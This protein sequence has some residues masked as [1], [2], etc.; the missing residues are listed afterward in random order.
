MALFKA[1][2]QPTKAFEFAENQSCL[3]ACLQPCR[4]RLVATRLQP[5]RYAFLPRSTFS[6]F[7]SRASAHPPSGSGKGG[8]HKRIAQFH[9]LY[10]FSRFLPKNR[11][12]SPKN[13]INHTNKRRSSWHVSYTQPA[14]IS[15]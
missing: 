6:S 13:D 15:R 5:L 2:L 3:R 10:F 14:I 1:R 8:T 11:V 9:C 12:S 4:K 7:F